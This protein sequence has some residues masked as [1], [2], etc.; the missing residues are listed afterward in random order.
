METKKFIQPGITEN[1][2]RVHLQKIQNEHVY[3]KAWHPLQIL[4]GENTLLQ[5]GSRG[6]DNDVFYEPVNY[7][8]GKKAEGIW[9]VCFL[10]VEMNCDTELYPTLK[11][12]SVTVILPVE[13]IFLAS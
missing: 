8:V 9:P 4:F 3:L 12:V 13:S 1:V 7:R 10:N 11:A 5:F 2:V 6:H